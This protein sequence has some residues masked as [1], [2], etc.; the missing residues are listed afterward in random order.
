[1]DALRFADGSLDLIWSEGAIYIMGFARGLA[2]WRRFLAPGGVLAVTELSWLGDA[3]PDEATGFWAA[4]YPAMRSVADNRALIREAGFRV[5]EH[6]ALPL[7]DWTV[8]YLRPMMARIR[9]LRGR[10]AGNEEALRQLDREEAEAGVLARTG[11]AFGYVF[12]VAER[13][14]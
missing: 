3:R 12:Y 8:E 4:N 7:T 13:D 11:D 1:M 10:Y 5:L 14:A 9:A 2:A 6:F